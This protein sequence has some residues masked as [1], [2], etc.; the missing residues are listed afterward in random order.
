MVINMNTHA[1][2]VFLVV[3]LIAGFLASF[4]VGGRGLIHYLLTGVIGAVVGGFLFSALGIHLGIGN[5]W[6]KEI[7]QATIGAVVVVLAA[8]MLA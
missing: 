1:L 4:I 5:I 7:V 8:R 6:V 3:G 2:I